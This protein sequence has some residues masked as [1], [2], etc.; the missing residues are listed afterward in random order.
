MT[1]DSNVQAARDLL[2]DYEDL[3][4]EDKRGVLQHAISEL[5]NAQREL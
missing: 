4:T 1:A 3:P 2:A 5:E